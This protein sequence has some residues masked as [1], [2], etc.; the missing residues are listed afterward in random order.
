MIDEIQNVIG[1]LSNVVANI[2]PA[3]FRNLSRAIM[4]ADR[5][6][7]AG[8]GRSGLMIRAFAM[9]LMHM[10]KTT[11]VVGDVTT[12]SITENDLL[13][14]ASGSGNTMSLV[15]MAEKAKAAN[16]SLALITIYPESSIGEMAECILTIDAPAK[17]D[18]AADGIS[19][20]PMATLFEQGMLICLDSLVL[21]LMDMMGI[22]AHEMYLKHANLE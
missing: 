18:I 15:N 6:F 11:Y 13:L 17:A 19:A 10:G 3:D 1:E 4:D 22:A 12:P 5:V 9:R 20:Q 7:V 2:N 16:A 21:R 8:M 14:V